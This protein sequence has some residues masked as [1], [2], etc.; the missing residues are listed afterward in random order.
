[1]ETMYDRIKRMTLGEMK[2]FVY[3]V[4]MNGNK[5]GEENICDS[6]GFETYFGGFVLTI[7]ANELM[8]NGNVEDLWSLL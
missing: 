1:M 6:G 7:P 5:D 2:E 8:P 3:W 4:Y